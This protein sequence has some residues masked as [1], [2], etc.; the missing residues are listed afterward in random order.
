MDRE[1]KLERLY[2]C[3]KEVLWHHLRKEEPTFSVWFDFEQAMKDIERA[4]V[5]NE[6]E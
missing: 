4:P 6:D 3:S 2:E 1:Q 5:K